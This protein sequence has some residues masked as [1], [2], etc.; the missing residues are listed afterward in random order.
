MHF[1][2]IAMPARGVNF[3][4]RKVYIKRKAQ[5]KSLVRFERQ[6]VEWIA[7]HFLGTETGERR[8]GA[9]TI[10]K[11]HENGGFFETVIG[12]RFSGLCFI[13]YLLGSVNIDANIS[14]NTCKVTQQA[15]CTDFNVKEPT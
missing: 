8:G 11:R 2:F 4:E 5:Y 9:V 15:T 1:A 7:N 14:A 6:N 12:S 10:D 13:F 3:R